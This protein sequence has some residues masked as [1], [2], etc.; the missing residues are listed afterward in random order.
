MKNFSLI[1][2]AAVI[3]TASL[4]VILGSF[5]LYPVVPCIFVLLIAAGDYGSKVRYRHS[6]LTARNED[7]NTRTAAVQPYRL[8]A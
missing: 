6:S 2:I 8:A 5:T 1:S 3:V 7:L 4:P